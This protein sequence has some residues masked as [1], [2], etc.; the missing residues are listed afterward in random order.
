MRGPRLVESIAPLATEGWMPPGSPRVLRV[1]QGSALR[2]WDAL[3]RRYPASCRFVAPVGCIASSRD[4][5]AGGES[6]GQNPGLHS[7]M[8]PPPAPLVPWSHRQ[9]GRGEPPRARIALPMRGPYHDT[10]GASTNP[11]SLGPRTETGPRGSPGQRSGCVGRRHRLPRG[12]SPGGRQD[13]SRNFASHG[14][15]RAERGALLKHDD[16]IKSQCCVQC[17]HAPKASILPEFRYRREPGNDL[18]RR[19][20]AQ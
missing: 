2:N 3:F 19:G 4:W 1:T 6:T 15:R 9:P 5:T 16:P 20:G 8:P 14:A 13:S 17:G 18:S 7:G 12:A 11:D 10:L